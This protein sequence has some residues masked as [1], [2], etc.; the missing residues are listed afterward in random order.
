MVLTPSDKLFNVIHK[1]VGLWLSC[2]FIYLFCS[3]LFICS[4]LFAC[5]AHP[6]S[7]IFLSFPSLFLSTPFSSPGY[8]VDGKKVGKT[9]DQ[10]EISKLLNDA[11]ADS[12]KTVIDT[13]NQRTYKLTPTDIEV[14]L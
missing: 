2:L 8:S 5:V 13:K 1:V 14:G 9:L 3:L 11:E 7:A 6:V 10:S 12:W 4:L